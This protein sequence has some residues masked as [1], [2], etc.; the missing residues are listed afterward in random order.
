MLNDNSFSKC[1]G[2]SACAA[3]CPV[4]AITM[5]EDI[6][7]FLYPYIDNGKC[8]SCNV[9][10]KV[11]PVER[12]LK[13]NSI[14][15]VYA[16][17]HNNE[18]IRLGSSSGGVFT[19]M[20]EQIIKQGGSVYGAKFDEHFR[21]IHDRAVS[22]DECKKF[23]GAK[24]VQSAVE[25]V[26]QKITDDL[27]KGIKVLFTGTPCQVDGI[28]SY[29]EQKKTAN[30][31][32]LIT[33]DIVCHGVASPLIWREYIDF[34]KKDKDITQI[35]FRNK[36]NGW[37]KSELRI[38]MNDGSY[39][40]SPHS[41]NP[42]SQMYFNHYIT[43]PYCAECKYANISR[44]GDITIGDFWG[45][46]NTFPKF[47]DDKGVSLVMINTQAGADFFDMIKGNLITVG[48]DVEHS[49]QPSLYQPSAAAKDRALFWN[50][51]KKHGLVYVMRIFVAYESSRLS[52]KLL[53]LK[54][55]SILKLRQL[56]KR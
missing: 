43:R 24:Y 14:R 54:R 50:E 53:K 7:G 49:Q 39:S 37:H 36:S 12:P 44:V 30:Q 19:A 5:N 40:S 46:E 22:M 34:A 13:F 1:C 47:D 42:Y 17:K 33:C 21:V 23:R 45:I 41:Q 8:V 11:C 55:R 51:Y 27:S 25:N 48:T 35:T 15:N 3:V 9:C 32:N 6:E 52:V 29:L 16:V 56:M 18:Q 28:K 4:K 2:C 31:N 38:D 26:Y 20:A 10:S